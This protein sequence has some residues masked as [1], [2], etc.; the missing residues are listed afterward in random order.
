SSLAGEGVPLGITAEAE[1]PAG[2]AVTLGPGDLLLL[3]T[4]G[5]VEARAPDGMFFGAQRAVD[6]VRVYRR[7]P[8]ARIVENLYQAVR[9]FTHAGPQADHLTALVVK[10]PAHPGRGARRVPCASRDSGGR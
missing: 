8:A 1:F 7:D 3:L 2:P 10:L 6:I 4:D 9:A 5:I